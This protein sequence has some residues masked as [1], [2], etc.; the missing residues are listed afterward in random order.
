MSQYRCRICGNTANNAT[1]EV[2]EMLHGTRAVF[3]YFQCS[4]CGCL[5]IA[6]VPGDLEYYYPSDYQAYKSYARK[7]KS[8]PRHFIDSR[9]VR[10]ALTGEGWLGRLLAKILPAPDYV[11]WCSKMGFGQNAKVLDVG[12][13]HGRLL[14]RMVAGGFTNLSG[15]DPFIREDIA[16]DGNAMIYKRDLPTHVAISGERYDLVMLHHSFEH[17]DDP[18]QVLVWC[19]TLL[20]DDGWLLIRIPLADSL[21]W[22][23]YRE[24]WYQ[25]DAPRHLYLHTSRSIHMLVAKRGLLVVGED[26]DSIETQFTFSELYARDIAANAPRVQR[27]IFSKREIREFSRHARKLNEEGKGDQGV[28]Y[29]RKASPKHGQQTASG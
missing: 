27:D 2:R 29:I 8:K 22:E 1:Y 10:Y 24:N 3:Q 6:S 12:C 23:R 11:N 28:F 25:L 20:K 17:M 14:S 21:A 4:V 18:G 15:I 26:R 16:I 5:Q 13:G 9:R 19:S 7:A